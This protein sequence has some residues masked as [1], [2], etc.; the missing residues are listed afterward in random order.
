[1]KIL[2]IANDPHDIGGVMNYTRPLAQKFFELGNDVFYFYSGAWNRQY[3]WLLKPYVKE[4]RFDSSFDCAELIN[5]PCW[6]R[7]FGNPNI[8]MCEAQTEKLFKKYLDRIKPDVVHIHSRVGLPASIAKCAAVCEIPVINSIHVYGYLCQKSVMIDYSGNLCEG[9]SNMTKCALCT[10]KLNIRKLKFNAR[11]MNTSKTMLDLMV[12]AKRILKGAPADQLSGD[13]HIPAHVS[14]DP[15]LVEGLARRLEYMVNLMNSVIDRTICVSEDVK[16]TLMRFGVHEDRLLVQHIGSLI[17]ETQRPRNDHF[18]SPIVIGN[19]GGVGHYKGTHVLINAVAK[20]KSRGFQVKIFGKY[21]NAF[22]AEIMK[23]RE[24]LP[25]EF[26]GRY[27]PAQLPEILDQVDIMVL[28]SICNDTAPQTI[29]ESY[30]RSVPI[31]A[32]NIGGFPD[33]V[34]DGVNGRLFTPGDADH[35]AEILDEIVNDPNQIRTFTKQIPKLKTI[36]QNADELLCLYKS[37]RSV[38]CSM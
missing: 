34:Q 26:T 18:H 29:F 21:E 14:A 12:F 19:I 3:N 28:P 4:T 23:G 5:S 22:K 32:S 2:L 37:L 20:M 1:M 16:K 15:A 7:N 9:P 33:F 35:L 27:V 10:G 30:S 17:A 38:R 8:D 13:A 11:T 6:S 31:V 25:V 24:N 36:Q